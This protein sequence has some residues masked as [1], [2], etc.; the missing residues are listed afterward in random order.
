MKKIEI[1]KFRN[2]NIDE[3]HKYC[4]KISLQCSGTKN[5]IIGEI[6]KHEVMNGNEVEYDGFLEMVNGY[7]FLRDINNNFIPSPYDV[8]VSTKMIR[9]CGLRVGDH[10]QCEI[11]MP[12]NEEKK[13]LSVSKVIKINGQKPERRAYFDDFTPI[14]PK[15]QIILSREKSVIGRMID[16]MCPIG[17]GQRALVV[18]PPKTG[19]TTVLHNIALGILENYKD[20][21][22]I[23]LLIDERP[24]EVTEMKKIAPSAEIVFS[25]FDESAENHTRTAEMINERAKRLVEM[26]QKVII[27]MDSITRLVRSYNYVVPS[28]GRV[29]TGGVEP[30]SLHKPKRFFGAARNTKE[31]GSLTIIA[32]GLVETG[33]KMDD[34]IYE[35]FKGTGNCEIKLDREIANRRVFP[36]IDIRNSGTRRYEEMISEEMLPKIR[37]IE[38]FLANMDSLEAIKF[39]IERINTSRSNRELISSMQR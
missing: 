36:A 38:S 11:T 23:I 21:K 12:K 18:A 5:N 17:F 30:A 22:L 8:Y 19:K 10:I 34:F 35:E 27:L 39:L 25:T 29:L 2:M 24:E 6:I 20:V 4:S 15:E 3:L 33:S 16:L 13:L 7:G 26:G 9:E 31:G 14:Y 28:S 37:I 1:E 32:T